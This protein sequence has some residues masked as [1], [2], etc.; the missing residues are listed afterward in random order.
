ME[1]FQVSPFLLV[2]EWQS[3]GVMSE[4]QKAVAGGLV[5]RLFWPRAPLI[6]PTERIMPTFAFH[7][8]LPATDTSIFALPLL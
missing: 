1:K 4:V 2:G 7:L 6:P 3:H 5:R 8:D